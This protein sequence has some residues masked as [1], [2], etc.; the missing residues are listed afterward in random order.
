MSNFKIA[1]FQER[2][3]Q[4]VDESGK[5]QSSIA[6]DFGVAKQTISAWITGANS[7]RQPIIYALSFYFNVSIPWLMGFDVPRNEDVIKEASLSSGE[8]S[9]VR[10]YRA[11]DERAQ[12]DALSTL[13]SHPK[14]QESASLA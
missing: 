13:L 4:L 9:L 14:K 7:P 1:T 2:L 6:S 10:A 3:A 5:S 8:V 12:Q 11:A